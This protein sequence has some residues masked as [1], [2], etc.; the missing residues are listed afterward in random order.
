MVRARGGL[1]G[2]CT[3]SGWAQRAGAGVGQRR[4]TC[5]G[6]NKVVPGSACAQRVRRHHRLPPSSRPQS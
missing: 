6:A 2:G 5:G 4:N 3:A 1:P